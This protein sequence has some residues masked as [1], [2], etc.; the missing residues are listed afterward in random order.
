M[1]KRPGEEDHG[2]PAESA[3]V[4]IEI[5]AGH[6]HRD[7]MDESLEPHEP[8]VKDAEFIRPAFSVYNKE[9]QSQRD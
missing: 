5:P 6:D 8:G 9:K 3:C 4:S 7:I 2:D 1:N